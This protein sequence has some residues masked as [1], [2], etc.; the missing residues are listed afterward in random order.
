M[1][2]VIPIHQLT[3]LPPTQTAKYPAGRR[4]RRQAGMHGRACLSTLIG[5]RDEGKVYR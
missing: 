2:P 1:P 4:H 5:E 3:S